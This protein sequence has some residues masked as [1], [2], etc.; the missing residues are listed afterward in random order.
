[1]FL[2]NLTVDEFI[3]RLGIKDIITNED[4]NTLN[5]YRMENA[6]IP[7]DEKALHI[8]DIPFAIHISEPIYDNILNMLTKYNNMHNFNEPLQIAKIEETEDQK[9]RR[10]EKE[11]KEIAR[12]EAKNDPNK[13]WHVQY[14]CLIP[15][16]VNNKDYYYSCFI[17]VYIK[18]FYNIP[19]S[20]NGNLEI[21]KDEEGLH[22]Y[23][24]LTDEN[25]FI[26]ENKYDY[27]IGYGFHNLNGDYLA[28]GGEKDIFDRTKFSIADGI[29]NYRKIVNEHGFRTIYWD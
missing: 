6:S 18:G 28:T 9:K 14:Y 1:M 11:A 20:V 13:I 3:T 5:K 8:F 19:D 26:Q 23:F 21:W 2:G 29:D 17:N 24:I 7:F 15:V 10:L 27:V 22:G 16:I 12:E 25:E 4:K